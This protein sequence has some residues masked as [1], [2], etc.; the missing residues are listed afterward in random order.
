MAIDA[1]PG[2]VI[3]LFL[4]KGGLVLV[5]GIAGGLLGTRVA[6]RLLASELHGVQPFDVLTI[7]TACAFVMA[8]GGLAIW[9]PAK[10]ATTQNLFASLNEN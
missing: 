10:R 3:R 7:A 1:T 6:A 8:A 5:C 4:K 9:S 2:A